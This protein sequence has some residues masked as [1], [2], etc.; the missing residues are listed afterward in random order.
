MNREELIQKISI[1]KTGECFLVPEGDYGK[2][3]IWRIHKKLFVFEI[4][5]YGGEPKFYDS[6]PVSLA[7]AVADVVLSWI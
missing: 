2:A 7:A 4:P 1:L 6:Y 3:E 5:Q